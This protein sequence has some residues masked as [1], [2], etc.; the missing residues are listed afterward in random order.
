MTSKNRFAS[1]TGKKQERGTILPATVIG[2]A[3]FLA[4]GSLA[5]DISHQMTA[6]VELQNAADAAMRAGVVE[7]DQTAGGI[8]RAVSHAL[9]VG[10]TY[11]WGTSL[12]LT[13]A[14]VTFAAAQ[15]EFANGGA[16]RSEAVA[17]ANPGPIAFMRVKIPLRQIRGVFTKVSIGKTYLGVTREAIGARFPNGLIPAPVGSPIGTPPSLTDASA[18]NTLCEWV[19]LS[20]LQDPVNFIPLNQ[21]NN[22]GCGN[23][24]KFSPGCTYVIKAGSN[25]TGTGFVAGGNFQAL[26][27]LNPDGSRMDTGGSDLRAR[28]ALW[29][30]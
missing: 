15:S 10:N 30:L 17:A 11:E 24:Y 7:L 22:G 25:G 28:I 4:I 3:V 29:R 26:A 16:G 2:L 12:N 13:R 5:I 6:G 14:D 27:A 9:A 8:T 20:V 1:M 19:P 21:P 18:V 23:P